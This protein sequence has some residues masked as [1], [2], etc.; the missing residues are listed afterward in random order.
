M[1][2]ETLTDVFEC[3]MQFFRLYLIRKG[4]LCVDVIVCL[5]KAPSTKS[6]IP[7]PEEKVLLVSSRSSSS[8]EVESIGK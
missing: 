8:S 1:V 4:V 3:A 5:R 7:T 2:R 6:T